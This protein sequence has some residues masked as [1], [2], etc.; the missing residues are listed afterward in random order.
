MTAPTP[1]NFEVD[2]LELHYL[3]GPGRTVHAVD[4]VSFALRGR[5]TALGVVGES[6]EHVYERVVY[7][8]SLGVR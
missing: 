6:G 2:N 7:F 3:G 8:P 1:P 4:G 5:G